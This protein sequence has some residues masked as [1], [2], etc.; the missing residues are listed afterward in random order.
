[1]NFPLIGKLFRKDARSVR[2]WIA[3]TWLLAAVPI[4]PVPPRFGSEEAPHDWE[5]SLCWL[6]ALMSAVRLAQMDDPCSAKGFMRTRPASPWQ[7]VFAK[8]AVLAIGFIAPIALRHAV[9]LT[10]FRLGLGWDDYVRAV[11]LAA[12]FVA[13][14]V[15]IAFLV[16]LVAPRI[17]YLVAV[18]MLLLFALLA[19]RHDLTYVIQA[20]QLVDSTVI[21]DSANAMIQRELIAGQTLAAL[22]AVVAAGIYASSR[23]WR[24][25][26]VAVAGS[27]VVALVAIFLWPHPVAGTADW[28]RTAPRSEWPDASGVVLNWDPA[29]PPGGKVASKL[30]VFLD[31]YYQNQNLVWDGDNGHVDSWPWD[32]WPLNMLSDWYGQK[33]IAWGGTVTG[34]SP[35]WYAC[36]VAFD[37]Q[38]TLAD[39][40]Q[41]HSQGDWLGHTYAVWPWPSQSAGELGP[42]PAGVGGSVPGLWWSGTSEDVEEPNFARVMAKLYNYAVDDIGLATGDAKVSGQVT[43]EFRRPVL[44]GSLPL[45]V[46]A[47]FTANRKRFTIV[48]AD[49]RGQ[50]LDVFFTGLEAMIPL[51][52]GHHAHSLQAVLYNPVRHQTLSGPGAVDLGRGSNGDDYLLWNGGV[53]WDKESE[54]DMAG[55]DPARLPGASANHPLVD[56]SWIRDARI[57]FIESE[58]GGRKT[59]P[60]DFSG[61]TPETDTKN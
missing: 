32:K 11:G 1:M 33:Y 19:F 38:L 10:S 6:L 60:F 25:L 46:G 23:S 2:W 9:N 47:T 51:R 54:E 40:R 41:F 20:I 3:L 28:D 13:A 58:A 42:N 59:V 5:A 21:S 8:C 36:P 27:V 4:N 45:K 12:P 17:G 29:S 35:S 52:G 26:A 22:A 44:L 34:L 49:F 39:G 7:Q 18:S 14:A 43:L 56:E 61:L 57:C 30:P 16:G 31:S 53:S 15:F 24:Q 55:H 50:H 48:Q 37:G